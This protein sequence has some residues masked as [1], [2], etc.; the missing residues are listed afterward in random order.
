MERMNE[1]FSAMMVPR[2]T[3]IATGACAVIV[4]S[5]RGDADH[6]ECSTWNASLSLVAPAAPYGVSSGGLLEGGTVFT[7]DSTMNERCSHCYSRVDVPRGTS[8]DGDLSVR[9]AWLWQAVGKS[10]PRGT[11]LRLALAVH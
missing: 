3:L 9:G 2:G 1:P 5:G 8:I 11:P 6:G 10:V 4:C 7:T